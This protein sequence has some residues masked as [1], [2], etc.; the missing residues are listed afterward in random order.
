MIADGLQEAIVDLIDKARSLKWQHIEAFRIWNS[1][2]V[3]DQLRAVN[4]LPMWAL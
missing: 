3:F 1:E 4:H 2:F